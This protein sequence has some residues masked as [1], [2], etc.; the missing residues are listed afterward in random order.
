M[1]TESE[2]VLIVGGGVIGLCTAWYLAKAGR[3]VT[4]LDRDPTRKSACSD[5]NAGMVVP[6]HFVPLAAPGIIAQGIKWMFNPKS[7]FSFRPSLNP[8]LWL[9]C[10]RFWRHANPTHVRNSRELLRD[11]SLESRRLF[12]DLEEQLRFGLVT[13][14]LVMLCRTEEGLEEESEYARMANEI[15]VDAEICSPERLKELDPDATMD[16][17]G[18]V[19]FGQDCHLDPGHFLDTLRK[20][21]KASGG[22]FLDGEATRFVREGSRLTAV[23][24][25]GGEQIT[26]GQFVIAGGAWSPELTRTLGLRLP[27]QAGKGYSLT[28]ANPTQR[29]QLCSLLKEARVAVTPMG[30]QLRVAGTMEICGNN[31]SVNR[32]RLQGVIESFCRFFPAFAPEDFAGL[33]PWAGLRPCSP[34]GLPYLGRPQGIDNTIVATG[35]SMLGLSLGP[36]TG[37]SVAKLLAGETPDFDLTRLAPDRFQ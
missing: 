34:D 37:Q 31:L 21:I 6:S 7:P 16:V 22:R 15:G 10:Y 25:S 20:D 4:V 12:L 9:W 33:E 36:V 5:Q 29:P 17:A 35:H 24:T 28:L 1:A 3:E 26:S 30:D 32:T 13:R 14:G 23:E 18:G 11:L 2:R 19:W 8:S 27:M